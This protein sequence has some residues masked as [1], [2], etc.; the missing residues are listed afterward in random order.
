MYILPSR[1]GVC[2]TRTACSA[3]TGRFHRSATEVGR[4]RR[5]RQQSSLLRWNQ[6]AREAFRYC[7]GIQALVR[8]NQQRIMHDQPACWAQRHQVLPHAV[9]TNSQIPQLQYVVFLRRSVMLSI[10]EFLYVV[11][12]SFFIS[13]RAAPSLV[14]QHPMPSAS[15]QNSTVLR[16][17]AVSGD[18]TVQERELHVP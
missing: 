10:S 12:S 2:R 16:S 4:A 15:R 1:L 9:N 18:T 17:E 14:R 6:R 13:W 11:P 5:P 7:D 3:G 8:V